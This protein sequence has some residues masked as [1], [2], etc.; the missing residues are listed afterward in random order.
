MGQ[1][2]GNGP[3]GLGI[4]DMRRHQGRI[5]GAEGSGLPLLAGQGAQP[6][7]W[8]QQG[9]PCPAPLPPPH[10]GEEPAGKDPRRAQRQSQTLPQPNPCSEPHP[11]HTAGAAAAEM[12]PKNWPWSP[13]A[14]PAPLPSPGPCRCCC[15]GR[16]SQPHPREDFTARTRTQ[17]G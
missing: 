2:G 17:L 1:Q 9:S 13:W 6:Q 3:Q 4:W 15:R 16:G 11:W 12:P 5:Q 14:P 8:P 10:P 7:L